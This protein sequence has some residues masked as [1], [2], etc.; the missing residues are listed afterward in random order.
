MMRNWKNSTV[1][2][3]IV[4]PQQLH[5]HKIAIL[6][7]AKRRSSLK[8]SKPRSSPLRPRNPPRSSLKVAATRRKSSSLLQRSPP[9]P[10]L[11][12]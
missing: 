11:L 4:V 10:P 5:R 3:R 2:V 7:T 9:L 1:L 6:K 8:R 12:R